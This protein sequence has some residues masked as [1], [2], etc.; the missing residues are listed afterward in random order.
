LSITATGTAPPIVTAG[1]DLALAIA[2]AATNAN[3]YPDGTPANDVPPISQTIVKST[4]ECSYG[5]NPTN[6]T[7]GPSAQVAH[8]AFAAG[9]T[10]PKWTA[11]SDVAWLA[12]TPATGSG[13][14]TLT[15]SLSANESTFGRSATV[16]I[17]GKT[18]Q[19][20]QTGSP[21]ASATSANQCATLRLQ[22]EGDQINAGGL[23]GAVSFDVIADAQCAWR[24]QSDHTWIT[25]TAGGGGKGNGIISYVVERNDSL[26]TRNGTI[27]IITPGTLNKKFTVIQGNIANSAGS[28]DGGGDGS[29]GAGSGGGSSGGD[30]G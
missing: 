18:I 23:T 10:C 6:L 4:T 8:L 26:A 1:A 15:L 25:L 13:D 5:L 9:V 29:G 11:Q 3:G 27:S 19:V 22:R 14:A 2:A 12:V 7:L 20:R 30:S 16:T 28:A 24:G 17:A 21:T